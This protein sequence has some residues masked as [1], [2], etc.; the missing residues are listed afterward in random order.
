MISFST[1]L[2]T[3]I[4]LGTLQG[5]IICCLLFYSKKNRLGNRLLAKLIFLMSL[6]SLNL[7][8]NE[9]GFFNL[10]GLTSTLNA[11][12]PMVVVMPMGPLI[13]FYIQSSLDPEFKIT[14]NHRL[15]FLPIIIDLVPSFT[16]IIFFAGVYQK[17]IRPYAKPWGI[18]IDHYNTYADVPR[19][20][21][22][23]FYLWLSVRYLLTLKNKNHPGNGQMAVFKWMQQFVYIFLVFQFI[24]LL[25]LVP[26]V[27]PQYT[28]FMLDTFKWYPVYIPLAILI[29]WLGIKGYLISYQQGITKKNS[30][31]PSSLSGTSIDE[32]VS[33]LKKS[34]ED[35]KIYL[36]PNL[37]LNLL[38]I[39]IGI[40][41]KTIS[42]VLNQHLQKSFNEFINQYRVDAVKTKLQQPETVNLTIAGIAS[43]C[44]FNSQATFQ[45][46]FKE[47]TGM[48]PSEY[49]KLAPEI[50]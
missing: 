10:N 38:A 42:A 49:R 41:Q 28:D 8:L 19:W 22:I 35:D 48:S 33:L 45:R 18:F 44:G 24:W 46:T 11:L 7:Y 34:M 25:Y 17:V 21:S 47:L 31:I 16:V 2:N 3:I 12:L 5:F 4:L 36:D 26:Y 30:S 20:M 1:F 29:Y 6:A 27:I 50:R 39:H 32:T 13:Y 43:T 23:T 37:N 40:G 9:V 14:K 15:H